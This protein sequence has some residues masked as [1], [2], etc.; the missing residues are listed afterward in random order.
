MAG[1]RR[2]GPTYLFFIVSPT[3]HPQPS[4]SFLKSSAIIPLGLVLQP[5][6]TGS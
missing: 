1:P 3:W 5:F 4:S 2:E 6:L